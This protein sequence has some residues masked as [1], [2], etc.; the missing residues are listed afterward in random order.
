ML[1]FALPLAL[2]LPLASSVAAA[3]AMWKVSDADSAIYLFGSFHVLPD[4]IDWRTP[5]F[6][7]RLAAADKIVLET[8][9]SPL[10]QAQVGAAAIA[11]GVYVDGTLLTDVID[12]DLEATLRAQSSAYDVPV[13]SLLA[14][15]PWMAANTISVAAMMA[16]GY[17]QP[18]VEFQ[19]EPEIEPDRLIHLET[20]EEQLDVLAGASDEEQL[21]MLQATLDELDSMPKLMSK[22][23]H[24]W[25]AG[26]ADRIAHLFQMEMGGFEDA[27]LDRL[28][29]QRN[30]NWVEPLSQL[31]ADDIDALVIVGAAHLVGP[32]NVIELLEAEGFTA[33]RV[34]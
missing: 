28:L 33:T 32:T 3:P 20:G 14:M 22:M 24:H 31:L 19:I 10:A 11:R 25:Q 1:R 12:D 17:D 2:L 27:F 34:Q 13:G 9:V 26:T 15:R 21:V 18:G 5:L 8:D 23:I 30:R 16:L 7:E 6:D 29:Y 4:G